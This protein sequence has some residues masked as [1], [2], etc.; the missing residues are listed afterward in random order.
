VTRAFQFGNQL[1][2]DSVWANQYNVNTLQAPFD[3]FKKS[4]LCRE[5]GLYV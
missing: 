1:Q 4:V 2:V 3:G 5:F